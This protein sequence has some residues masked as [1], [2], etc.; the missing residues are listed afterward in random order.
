MGYHNVRDYTCAGRFSAKPPREGAQ[1]EK[2]NECQRR[3]I[4]A[5]SLK[6]TMKARP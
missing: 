2:E 4:T 1:R 6:A 3:T 5:G